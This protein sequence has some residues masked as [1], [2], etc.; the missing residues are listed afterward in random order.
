M[1]NRTGGV[2]SCDGDKLLSFTNHPYNIFNSCMI[3]YWLRM[4]TKTETQKQDDKTENSNIISVNKRIKSNVKFKQINQHPKH[5]II[6]YN[7]ISK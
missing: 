2:D 4:Y 5:T 1:L 7:N 3:Y 6:T